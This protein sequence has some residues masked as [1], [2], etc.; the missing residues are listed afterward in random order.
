MA[1][2]ATGTGRPSRAR[3]SAAKHRD[4]ADECGNC[5]GVAGRGSRVHGGLC[6]HETRDLCIGGRSRAA[7]DDTVGPGC[8]GRDDGCV[9]R[10]ALA[11]HRHGRKAL[12]VS[13]KRDPQR[14]SLLRIRCISI[15]AERGDT[16]CSQGG[17]ER[18]PVS[19]PDNKDHWRTSGCGGETKLAGDAAARRVDRQCLFRR[20]LRVQRDQE[21][22]RS[23]RRQGDCVSHTGGHGGTLRYFAL[24]R[25]MVPESMT[26]PDREM[27]LN[28]ISSPMISAIRKTCSV[29]SPF[30]M[31]GLDLSRSPGASLPPDPVTK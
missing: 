10:H 9:K 14:G 29:S 22:R 13:Q 8:A 6:R 18:G 25:V 19:G 30:A 31:I 4:R 24:R 5:G 15:N 16:L 28:V 23:Q 3:A 7:R 1:W 17:R 26:L 11:E 27:A 20:R 2:T 21:R 12:V